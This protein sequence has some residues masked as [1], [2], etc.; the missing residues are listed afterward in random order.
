MASKHLEKL[1]LISELDRSRIVLKQDLRAVSE[2]FS[3]ATRIQASVTKAPARWMV[4]AAALG[5]IAG[6]IF[7]GSRKAHIKARHAKALERLAAQPVPAATLA[8]VNAPGASRVPGILTDLLKFAFM[9]AKPLLLAYATSKAT[10]I[11]ALLT[12]RD[13]QRRK[14]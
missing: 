11:A 9:A 13:K 10:D 12:A 6:G 1:Q 5:I 14:K 3:F 4:G 8:A 7:R 2:K